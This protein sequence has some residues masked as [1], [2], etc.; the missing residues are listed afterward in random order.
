MRAGTKKQTARAS[1]EQI[2]ARSMDTPCPMDSLLVEFFIRRTALNTIQPRKRPLMFSR[3]T[4]VGSRWFQIIINP[5]V[6]KQG[7]KR[8]RIERGLDPSVSLLFDSFRA[9]RL[10]PTTYPPTHN[11]QTVTVFMISALPADPATNHKKVRQLPMIHTEPIHFLWH[12][13]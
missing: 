1:T 8:R 4:R 11:E 9:N 3:K 10:I 7:L 12:Q 13:S 6:S 2:P 5:S